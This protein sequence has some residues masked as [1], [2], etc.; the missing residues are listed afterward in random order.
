MVR[1]LEGPPSLTYDGGAEFQCTPSLWTWY[2]SEGHSSL[3]YDS[4]AE[5]RSGRT[6]FESEGL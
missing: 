4:G 6:L 1:E 2:E 3:T 5:F